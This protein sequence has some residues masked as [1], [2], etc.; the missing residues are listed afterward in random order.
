MTEGNNLETTAEYE[1]VG[2]IIYSEHFLNK[3]IPYIN[4]YV[5]EAEKLGVKLELI[6]KE[7]LAIGV[8]NNSISI[9]YAIKKVGKPDFV[10]MRERDPLLSRQLEQAGVK[11]FNNSKVSEICNDKANTHQ[12]LAGKNVKMLDTVFANASHIRYLPKGMSFPLM[13]KEVDGNDSKNVVKVNTVAELMQA[14]SQLGQSNIIVQQLAPTM[15][16]EIRIWLLGGEIIGSVLR[17][18]TDGFN[19]SYSRGANVTRYDLGDAE[20]ET[21]HQIASHI[22]AD[23]LAL[24]FFFGES[25]ELIL[26][27]IEEVA[28]SRTLSLVSDYNVAE[29]YLKYILN[30]I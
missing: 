2:W 19:A 18:A 17:T 5:E 13:V 1:K 25:G 20:K 3:N 29:N 8:I 23:F 7:G 22:N 14:C 6:L 9:Q 10:I 4:W 12:Y 21:V 15:G 27:E 28:G 24:D 16:Q 11:V 26:N 30:N